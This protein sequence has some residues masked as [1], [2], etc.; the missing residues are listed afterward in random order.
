[1]TPPAS[2]TLLRDM[3]VENLEQRT[4]RRYI[5]HEDR[6]VHMYKDHYLN[7]TDH[8]LFTFP[9]FRYFHVRLSTEQ[10][11]RKLH[12]SKERSHIKTELLI[13]ICGHMSRDIRCGILGP[14][15]ETTFK[16]ALERRGISVSSTPNVVVG[17]SQS[18][19]E[20]K[21][22]KQTNANVGLIS[23][24]G[25]HKWAGNVIIY[26]PPSFRVPQNMPDFRHPL[27]GTGIWYGRVEP[28]H[29][30]RIVDETILKGNVIKEFLRGGIDSN[31]DTI[32][33]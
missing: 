16:E 11:E 31:G 18:K 27:S 23:H 4:S 20:V 22:Q 12:V 1:M 17:G 32:M 8:V 26:T 9:T 19:D 3:E 21:G 6:I 24:I 10:G 13:L 7:G 30:E 2:T 29:V 25:G 14:L 5:R 28:K 33:F 15:L